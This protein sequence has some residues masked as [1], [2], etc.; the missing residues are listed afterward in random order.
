MLLIGQ[1]EI[2]GGYVRLSFTAAGQR[3]KA[4]TQLTADQINSYANKR[5]LIDAGF[6]AVFPPSHNGGERF[7]RHLGAGQY[8][9][10]EGRKLNERPLTKTEAE[11][12]AGLASQP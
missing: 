11:E 7:T 5:R 10:I 6:I 1:K 4:G 9:V 3:L 8:D 12:L 2:G